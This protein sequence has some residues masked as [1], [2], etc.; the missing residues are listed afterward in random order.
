MRQKKY[1][2]ITG[3]SSGIGLAIAHELAKRGHSLLLVALDDHHLTTAQQQ[4]SSKYAVDVQHLG[5]DLS[6]DRG[7]EQVSNWVMDNNFAV[8]ILINNAGF[9]RNGLLESKDWS[10]YNTMIQLNNRA[11]VQLTYHLVS[12]LKQSPG[13]AYIMNMSSMEVPLIMPYKAVYAATKHFVFGFSLGLREELKSYGV[14]VTTVCP[15]PVMTN[16]DSKKRMLAMGR[17][18]RWIVL[19]PDEVARVAVKGL[20]NKRQVVVPGR[21]AATLSYVARWVPWRYKMPLLEKL[22]HPYKNA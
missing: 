22:F 15:G 7:P 9:G 21:M 12:M 2:L 3:G 6:Q 20:F 4:L 1:A 19:M 16:E 10:E 5:V 8:N 14:S 17:K 13:E 18:A 11:M